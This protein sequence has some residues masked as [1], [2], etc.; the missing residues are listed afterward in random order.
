MTSANSITV[1]IC[2]RDRADSL[3]TCLQSIA[4]QTIPPDEILVSD[5][6]VDSVETET[7]CSEFSLVTYMRGPQTGLCS[8]RNKVIA[9]AQSSYISLIDDDGVMAAD[10]IARAREHATK[11]GPRTI[12][13]GSVLEFGRLLF[14]PGSPDIW[15]NFTQNAGRR[16]IETIQLNSNLFPRVAFDV[17]SFDELIQYGFEDMDLCSH[18]LSEGYVISWDPEM[19]N[20]HFPPAQSH[21]M[22]EE[23]FCLWEQA[24]YYTSLKRN[25]IWNNKRAF[26]VFYV[27][28]APL[29]TM[30]FS[31]RWRKWSRIWDAIPNMFVAVQLFARFRTLSKKYGSQ[32][33]PNA[34]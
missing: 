32:R 25:F 1:C 31:A 30:A 17:A 28:A 33:S 9:A 7:V 26:G 4:Q 22:S 27:C 11:D 14:H 23:R 19:I 18:L 29:Y 34:N 2:T 12:T 13:T 21:A 15:G 8:N 5:D 10:F 3:R 24:R 20:S 16:G 6:S